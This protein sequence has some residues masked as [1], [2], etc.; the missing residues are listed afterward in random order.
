MAARRSESEQ[1]L[2][3]LQLERDN[4]HVWAQLTYIQPVKGHP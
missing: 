3:A 2:Q 4:A 1:R